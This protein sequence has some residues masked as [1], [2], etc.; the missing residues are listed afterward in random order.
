MD[1]GGSGEFVSGLILGILLGLVLGPILRLW[2]T[3]H[4]WVSASRQARLTEDVLKRMDEGP[5]GPRRDGVP[6]YRPRPDDQ[7]EDA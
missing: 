4:D 1:A 2:L 6:T 5:R 7:R 3:W